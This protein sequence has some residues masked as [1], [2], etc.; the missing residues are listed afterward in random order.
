MVSANHG[1][2]LRA[3]IAEL[4]KEIAE[5]EQLAKRLRRLEDYSGAEDLEE[6]LGELYEERE[7]L[8]AECESL[9]GQPEIVSEDS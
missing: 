5:K 3:E 2:A 7:R 9:Q 8:Q 4:V 6:E 1:E